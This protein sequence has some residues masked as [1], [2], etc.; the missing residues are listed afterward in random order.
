M[1]GF[2]SREGDLRCLRECSAGMTWG[3]ARVALWAKWRALRLRLA[4]FAVFGRLLASTGVFWA[5][6]RSCV[7][8]SSKLAV[9]AGWSRLWR[10]LHREAYSMLYV[11]LR[12]CH[13]C[14]S[15]GVRREKAL[16]LPSRLKWADL[17][18]CVGLVAGLVS[19]LWLD[20]SS[21]DWN[22]RHWLRL[23]TCPCESAYVVIVGR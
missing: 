5:E 3:F 7:C 1:L 10:R 13:D 17:E 8:L 4:S 15:W 12:R 19:A 16:D 21:K 2:G 9:V 11:R 14:T 18:E 6:C 23:S 20:G 22:R